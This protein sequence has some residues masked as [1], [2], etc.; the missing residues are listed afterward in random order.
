MEIV[1]LCSSR[2]NATFNS[3]VRGVSTVCHQWK[4]RNITIASVFTELKHDIRGSLHLLSGV[5]ARIFPLFC[6]LLLYGE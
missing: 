1:K 2:S 6:S 3:T 5:C 4:N